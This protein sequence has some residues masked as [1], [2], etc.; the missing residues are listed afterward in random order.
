MILNEIK[1]VIC[2][3]RFR[4]VKSSKQFVVGECCRWRGSVDLIKAAFKHAT[5]KI[6]A[7]PGFSYLFAFCT[8]LRSLLPFERYCQMLVIRPQWERKIL[9][10]GNFLFPP[11]KLLSQRQGCL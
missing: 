7:M 11:C 8:I 2:N 6:K 10:Y 1:N 9:N 3:K 5:L 4:V